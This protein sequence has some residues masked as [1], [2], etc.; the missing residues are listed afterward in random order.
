M[1]VNE[2]IKKR[3]EVE[4]ERFKT[5]VF[6]IIA[7]AGGNYGLIINLHENIINKV[8]LIFG[9]FFNLFFAFMA[10]YSYFKTNNLLKKLKER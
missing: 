10:I 4:T 6:V 9:L 1:E 2:A 7:L 8:L 5:Y 3:I